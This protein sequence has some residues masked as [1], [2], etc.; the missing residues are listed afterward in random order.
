MTALNGQAHIAFLEALSDEI[1]LS[2]SDFRAEK[3]TGQLILH[4]SQGEIASVEISEEFTPGNEAGSFAAAR[5]AM[6]AVKK[7]RWFILQKK[8]GNVTLY[9]EQGDIASVKTFI[10]LSP[11]KKN[12]ELA[13]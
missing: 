4:F 7:V 3:K 10:R 12:R 6:F 2:V 13:R 1:S 5:C 11:G 9:F 8:S